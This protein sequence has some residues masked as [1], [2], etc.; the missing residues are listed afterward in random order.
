MEQVVCRMT[1]PLTMW[2]SCGIYTNLPYGYDSTFQGSLP[3]QE[4]ERS[5]SERQGYQFD[6]D[7]YYYYEYYY[8]E[9]NDIYDR[10]DNTDKPERSRGIINRFL[11]FILGR[12]EDDTDVDTRPM[13]VPDKTRKFQLPRLPPLPSLPLI[14]QPGVVEDKSGIFDGVVSAVGTRQSCLQCG[15]LWNSSSWHLS[16]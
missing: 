3:G 7:D 15:I 10:I 9:D 6:D 4:S 5:I 1:N 8:D 12:T 14:N 16:R 11:D 13:V 2:S